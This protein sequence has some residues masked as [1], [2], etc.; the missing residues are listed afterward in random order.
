MAIVFEVHVLGAP[1]PFLFRAVLKA[2]RK[3]KKNCQP[4]V[5]SDIRRAPADEYLQSVIGQ[6]A[7]VGHQLPS[8][9]HRPASVV[10]HRIPPPIASSCIS[11]LKY[12]PV[13]YRPLHGG[14]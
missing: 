7:S 10:A 1:P 14:S 9:K 2:K 12:I 5:P 3:N 6:P 8:V 4:P 13:P 11:F